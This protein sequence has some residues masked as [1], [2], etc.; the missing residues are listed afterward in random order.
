MPLILLSLLKD[1]WKVIFAITCFVLWSIG[2]DQHGRRAV[3]AKWDESNAA[4]TIHARQIETDNTI[5]SGII[6]GKYESSIKAINNNFDAAVRS[7]SADT[8]GN[9]SSKGNSTIQ[10]NAATCSSSVHK[11]NERLKLAREAEVNTQQ[12][13]SLQEWIKETK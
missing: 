8:S 10:F 7:L 5:L 6:G 3:Y 9:L 4:A 2:C 1:N 11:T 12:L 13:I